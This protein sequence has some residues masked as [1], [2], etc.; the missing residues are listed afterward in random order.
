VNLCLY[1][2]C[3]CVSAELWVIFVFSF[4]NLGCGWVVIRSVT[5]EFYFVCGLVCILGDVL[6]E[7]SDLRNEVQCGV[8]GWEQICSEV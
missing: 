6:W 8:N 4:C 1:V 2:A 5:V 7:T 3:G